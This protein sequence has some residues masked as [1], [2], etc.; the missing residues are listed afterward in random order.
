MSD[1][2]HIQFNDACIY[3]DKIWFSAHSFNGIF[4]Y[5]LT[6]QELR[7]YGH[8]PFCEEFT[9]ALYSYA[10]CDGDKIIFLPNNTD[11]ILVYTP[12]TNKF[13]QIV[14]PVQYEGKSFLIENYLKQKD[15]LYLFP[16][17]QSEYVWRF[18][19][20]S[21]SLERCNAI[22]E[23]LYSLDICMKDT[24]DEDSILILSPKNELFTL[25][26]NRAVLRHI[27]DFDSRWQINRIKY[28]DHK[29]WILR[30]DSLNVYAL[31]NNKLTEYNFFEKVKW[32]E[33]AGC[34]YSNF[35]FCGNDVYVL[36]Y[37][38]YNIMR[39]N[40]EKKRVET[41]FE[42][43]H[44]FRFLK[45]F[46]RIAFPALSSASVIGSKIFFHPIWGNMLLIYD[47]EEKTISGKELYVR[48]GQLPFL[49]DFSSL[50]RYGL[51]YEADEMVTLGRFLNYVKFRDS[52]HN[53]DPCDTMTIGNEIYRRIVQE[54]DSHV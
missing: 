19:I 37:S 54:E 22:E 47:T 15:K 21:F 2:V 31:E 4:S 18:D 41:A 43:P 46:F 38:L 24:I 26:V 51:W 45:N 5:S 9:P 36:N 3:D 27:A 42:Y 34:P 25:D 16:A 12:K 7:F 23:V 20:L 28:H 49:A 52:S 8:I 1:K 44:G 30:R 35:V 39:L 11:K 6:D 33:T 40:H 29:F 17:S 13:Q 48:K 14:I 32:V 10:C 53:D 50:K